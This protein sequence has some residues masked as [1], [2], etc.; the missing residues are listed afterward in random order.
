MQLVTIKGKYG[1]SCVLMV[2]MWASNR[3]FT[4]VTKDAMMI[5]KLAILTWSGMTFLSADIAK[6]EAMRTK[7]VARPIDRPL[8]K[9]VVTARVGHIPRTWTNTGFS[10]QMPLT[11][12]FSIIIHLSP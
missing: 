12:S 6:P 7:V 8:I 10:F 9:E 2:G 5:I 3:S 11:K 1:P 4:T